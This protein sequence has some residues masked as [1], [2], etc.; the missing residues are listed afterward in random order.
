M[1]EVELKFPVADP[2]SVLARL[3]A[4]GAALDKPQLQTDRYFSHPSRDFARTDEALRLRSVGESHYITYKGPRLDAAAKTRKEIELLLG[5]GP[6]TL[7]SWCELLAALGFLHLADVRK[8]RCKAQL[9]WE[10]ISVQI[11]LDEVAGLGSFVELEAL[12]SPEHLPQAQTAVCGLAESM[13]LA[14][15]ERRT[16]LEL[17]LEKTRGHH[18]R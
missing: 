12:A 1:L 14:A 15:P 4:L 16:Y 2:S 7:A 13:G 5:E 6:Q 11:A 9:A 18:G 8:Q 17:L 10:G 3:Q